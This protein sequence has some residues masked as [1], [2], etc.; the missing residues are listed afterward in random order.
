[1]L[2]LLLAS[3]T[4]A[5]AQ[6]FLVLLLCVVAFLR[7][8]GPERAAIAVWVICVEIPKLIYRD[9]LGYDVQVDQ[10]DIYLALKDAAAAI[11]WVFLALYANRNYPLWI[12]GVQL[13]AVGAHVARGLLEAIAPIS[14][15]VLIVAPGWI[16]LLIMT[17]GFTRHIL[18]TRKFGKYR[19]WRISRRPSTAARLLKPG[20]VTGIH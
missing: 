4:R 18:R 7:G 15:A 14:Y 5:L 16:V 11:L 20:D 1:M 19:D 2:E 8:A 13:L 10:V 6:D 12:A 9:L 17:L 3:D